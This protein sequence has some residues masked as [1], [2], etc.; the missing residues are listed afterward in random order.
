MKYTI[1]ISQKRAVELGLVGKVDVIDLMIVDLF[2]AM[3]AS[4]DVPKYDH[5]DKIYILFTH[6]LVFSQIPMIGITHRV[7][8]KRR[9]KKLQEAG[10]IV[11]NP[12]NKKL[13]KAL[14][15]AGPILGKYITPDIADEY[16][17]NSKVTAPVTQ[18]LQTCNSKVTAPVTQKLHYKVII[19]KDIKNKVV[20]AAASKRKKV[21]AKKEDVQTTGQKLLALIEELTPKVEEHAKKEGIPESEVWHAYAFREWKKLFTVR[22]PKLKATWCEQLRLKMTGDE[23]WQEL[24]KF[25]RWYEEQKRVLLMPEESQKVFFSWLSKYKQHQITEAARQ[26]DR[27][28][29]AKANRYSNGKNTDGAFT[30]A[31][32]RLKINQNNKS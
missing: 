12:D 30:K 24:H 3:L 25:L 17:C 14:Y 15:T 1:A 2:A 26:A 13:N 4:P 6:N 28:Q 11:A 22:Y 32:D 9:M 20:E 27:A 21:S 16:T 7:A 10:L 8:L 31:A 19:D 29:V 23:F 5:G 18:K